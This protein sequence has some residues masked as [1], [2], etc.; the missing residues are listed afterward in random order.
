MV[1]TVR[2]KKC[3]RYL[4]SIKEIIGYSDHGWKFSCCG[5]QYYKCNHATC[6]HPQKCYIFY[7]DSQHLDF[8]IEKYHINSEAIDIT[9]A[10]G[11]NEVEN[12]I[13]STSYEESSS[14]DNYFKGNCSIDNSFPPTFQRG[15]IKKLITMAC[16]QKSGVT[17]L[18]KLISD[19]SFSIFFAVAQIAFLAND[20]VVKYLTIILSNILPIWR[21]FY[22]CP[23]D[24]P[25]NT[26]RI[27]SCITSNNQFSVRSL[28]PMPTMEDVYDHCYSSLSSLLAYT[29]MTSN[30]KSIASKAR[31]SSWMKSI[32]CMIFCNKVKECSKISPIPSVAVFMVFWSD[33]FD[34]TTSMKR[35]R[36]SVWIL[37]V[38]F[39]S[40]T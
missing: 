6:S 26:D 18:S 22:K 7:Q 5:I 16:T 10:V 35:N 28:I 12:Y 19:Q 14:I 11:D 38:T 4:S 1:R 21:S 9:D 30:N 8:H 25:T 34:P 36:R 27:K 29:T 23:L 33:G 39:F 40:L 13:V 31:Y 2:C 37:T 3:K 20:T 17:S 32:S 24:I 15:A